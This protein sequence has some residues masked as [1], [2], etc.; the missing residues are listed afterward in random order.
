MRDTAS[1]L[2]VMRAARRAFIH[3]T[4]AWRGVA[5]SR[6]SG[7]D[8]ISEHIYTPQARRRALLANAHAD[9]HTQ[10]RTRRHAHRRIA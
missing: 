7:R 8:Y 1:P 4:A 10:A 6:G 5:P 9:T 3:A 2:P